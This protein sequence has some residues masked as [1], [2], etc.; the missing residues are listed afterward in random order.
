[1]ELKQAF[2]IAELV[3]EIDR[4]EK[5]LRRIHEKECNGV[6]KE[7][8]NGQ[9]IFGWDDKDQERADK[10]TDIIINRV[11]HILIEMGCTEV[12]FNQGDPRGYSFDFRLK[13]GV[14]IYR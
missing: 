2:K 8:K 14:S 12:V 13:D 4:L 5:R 9:P 10:Q 6:Y 11:Q 3:K 1:M 7:F